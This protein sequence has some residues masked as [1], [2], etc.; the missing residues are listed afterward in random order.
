LR[1]TEDL[2]LKFNKNVKMHDNIL[3]GLLQV[4]WI[5]FPKTIKTK[6]L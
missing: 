4:K 6:G 3:I 5:L 2:K 1:V